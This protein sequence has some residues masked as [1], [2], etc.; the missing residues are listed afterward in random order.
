MTDVMQT[1]ENFKLHSS[2]ILGGIH[3][4]VRSLLITGGAGKQKNITQ[5]SGESIS[6]EV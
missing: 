6:E 2:H 5:T 3:S 1:C 4:L